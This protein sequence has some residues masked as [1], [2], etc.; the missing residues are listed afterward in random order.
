MGTYVQSLCWD[1]KKAIGECSWSEEFKPVKGWDAT[2]TVIKSSAHNI[3]PFVDSFIVH[4]CPLFDMDV[5]TKKK[6]TTF[7]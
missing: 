7:I 6:K 2:P 4:S 5:K 3:D 1:C